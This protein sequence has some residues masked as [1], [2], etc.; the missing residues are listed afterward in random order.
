MTGGALRIVVAGQA[1]LH[2]RLDLSHPG[3][4]QLCELAGKADLAL[5]NLEA[6]VNAPGA[7]PTKTRT[8]HLA[9]P[10]ALATLRRMGFGALGLANNH[11]F[12]L[13]PPG[14][15]AT[16]RA[17]A[18]CGLLVAGTG[19][20]LLEAGQAACAETGNGR[21]A[22]VSVDLGPQPDIVYAD[23]SRAGINPLRLRMS[24]DL[25]EAEYGVLEQ[26]MDETGQKAREAARAAIGFR[27]SL[28]ATATEFFGLR[29]RRGE[30]IALLL[31]P[32]P[33]D[34]ERVRS[35]IAD[36]AGRADRVAVMAHSHH[37]TADWS[38]SPEWFLSLARAM[39]DAGADLVVGTGAPVLQPVSFH[40]GRPIFS[41]LGN[42]VF[43][44]GRAAS[45]DRIGLPVW[46]GALVACIFPVDGGACRLEI[47]P[48]AAGRPEVGPRGPAS[49][50][51]P[52]PFARA[53]E[54]FDHLTR[55]LSQDQKACVSR[56]ELP[57][58]AMPN[59]TQQMEGT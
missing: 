12:D 1:C 42:L 11:A 51:L 18:R 8:L 32:D 58:P 45:Y 28:P 29:V 31:T 37:W 21:V 23:A 16:R 14:I 15:E 47:A 19:A 57:V 2:D 33:G 41:S 54:V 38:R 46:D 9:R 40:R 50:P 59:M 3:T 10:R 48:L 36:A 17:A 53:A 7:W 44:S 43:H 56:M 26:I 39:I 34:L 20:D 13:G 25:P 49:G 52:L 22:V 27:P 24:L 6:T 55:G 35:I 30:G 5:V 4:R